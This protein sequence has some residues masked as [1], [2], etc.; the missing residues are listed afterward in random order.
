MR[1][2]SQRHIDILR[3]VK[4]DLGFEEESLGVGL[5]AEVQRGAYV[6]SDER[7]DLA[8]PHA[9]ET[10]ADEHRDDGLVAVVE[11]AGAFPKFLDLMHG[12]YVTQAG[13]GA[14]EETLGPLFPPDEGTS[15]GIVDPF[16]LA[17]MAV[18]F[19]G[20]LA[21]VLF[22]GFKGVS[23]ES[24]QQG[25]D[26]NKQSLH[27][28]SFFSSFPTSFEAISRNARPSGRDPRATGSPASPPS[29]MLW[30]IGTCPSRS[31]PR[32]RAMATPPPCPNR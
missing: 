5:L 6:C 29:R 31:R 28:Q 30:T 26:Q 18:S 23:A 3:K 32:A 21:L 8:R 20:H 4:P 11:D 25:C 24:Q 1:V 10:C 12:V 7:L 17:Y 2:H 16:G 13:S 19:D 15:C 22:Y 14:E 27:F 9:S